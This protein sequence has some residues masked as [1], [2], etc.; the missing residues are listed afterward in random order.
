MLTSLELRLPPPV[1]ALLTALVMWIGAHDN[2]PFPRPVW[3]TPLVA[4]IGAVAGVILALAVTS[5]LQARTTLSPIRPGQ[6]RALV[7]T[8]I[9][10][11]TRNPIYLADA[12]ALLAYAFHLWQ[13][14]SFVAV[15]VFAAWIHRFQ[16]LPEER[17]LRATFG[18][19]FDQYTAATR[20]WL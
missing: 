9:Y 10:G 7:R 16:I 11:V 6:A 15:P 8:G 4:G 17:A 18:E 12:L 14:Q 1:L 13:P 19:D 2:A 3:L 5:L 20:R